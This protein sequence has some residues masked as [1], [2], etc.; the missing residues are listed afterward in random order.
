[1][2]MR[3]YFAPMEG[4]TG[5]LYR[6]AHHRY[7]TGVDKYF[8]PFLSPTQDNVFTKK[9]LG[10]ILPEHNEGIPVVPQL[11]T[12]RAADFIWA[13]RE[14]ERMGYQEVNLNLGC[15]SGTVVAKGKG[16]GLLAMPEELNHFLEEIFSQVG[17]EISVK[18]RLGLKSP[19]EFPRLLEIYNCYPIKE[20]TIHP[21]VRT[22]YYK[23]WVNVAT[24]EQALSSS[25]NPVCYNGDLVTAADCRGAE[26]RFPSAQALMLGRGLL[27][28]PALA[29]K[30]KGGP[31]ADKERLQA[32]HDEV[33]LGYCRA[34][35]SDRNAM[36]RMKEFWTYLICLFQDG[37][38]Y[39][40]K[41]KKAREPMEYQA[42]VTALFQDL[43]L[44]E[45]AAVDWK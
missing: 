6:R 39:A 34:F 30:A 15:P 41:L 31:G 25:H 12:R 18:T 44:R 29:G 37:D 8:M 21:R 22:D 27:A 9:E 45:E 13:A 36:L 42:Y 40:K 2:T 20:L 24:F 23:N 14:L 43:V 7:F 16:A 33:Y 4:V 3:Y 17:I 11:L 38:R 28:D 19:E 5:Q 10:E 32:F 26:A 1:M 35:G